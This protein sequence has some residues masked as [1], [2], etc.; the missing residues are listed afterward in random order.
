MH[1]DIVILVR[2]LDEQEDNGESAGL[3]KPAIG[4]F[5]RVR[6]ELISNK[7]TVQEYVL[8]LA[9]RPRYAGF[10]QQG[11]NVQSLFVALGLNQIVGASQ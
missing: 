10:A 2:H 11:T 7:A 8:K 1:I 9:V 4:F 5:D 3:Q 6:D